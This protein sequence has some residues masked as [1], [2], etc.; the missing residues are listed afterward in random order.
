MQDGNV[1]TDALRI[2]STCSGAI[3]KS[4]SILIYAKLLHSE[5]CGNARLKPRSRSMESEFDSRLVSSGTF[6]YDD[7]IH[8][9]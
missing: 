3:V 4:N 9:L 6:A 5:G 2:R 7:F 1:L 8:G